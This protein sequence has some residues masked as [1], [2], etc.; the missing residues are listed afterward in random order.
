MV[1]LNSPVGW[2]FSW[3]AA[4]HGKD[5]ALRYFTAFMQDYPIPVPRD[6]QRENAGAHVKILVGI[7][8]R[9]QEAARMLLDWLRMEYDLEKPGTKLQNPFGLDS[10]A[11]VNEVKKRRGKSRPLSAAG[12]RALREEYAAT[13]EPMRRRLAEGAQLEGR[14]SELVNAAYGL[15]EE[16]VDL[17]WRTAPPRMPISR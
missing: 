14:L 3:R 17:M 15:T 13:I 4:Q 5:E 7:A 1:V 6:E 2:W 10:D 11:F 12:L 16:E 9:T 8:Q